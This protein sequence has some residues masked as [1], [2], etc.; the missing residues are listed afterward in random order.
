MAPIFDFLFDG[1]P[2]TRFSVA[3]V[4]TSVAEDP[5][6]AFSLW[7]MLLLDYAIEIYEGF[8]YSVDMWL[9]MV[10][11]SLLWQ[12]LAPLEGSSS[13]ASSISRPATVAPD[14]SRATLLAYLPP[15]AVA[16]FQLTLLPMATANLLIVLYAAVAVGILLYV[17]GGGA[18][19]TPSRRAYLTH[20]AQ[21]ILLCLLFMALGIYL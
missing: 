17:S 19:I 5:I 20:Y 11:V 8:H 1:R 2:L 14:F 10:L 7:S 16:Y 12:V 13:P 3:C 4:S 6:F 15:A 18:D 21:H 9:G